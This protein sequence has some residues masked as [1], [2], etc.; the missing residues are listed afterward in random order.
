MTDAISEGDSVVTV[1]V[2][3]LLSKVKASAPVEGGLDRLWGRLRPR[4]FC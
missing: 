2:S 3:V 1:G 4:R